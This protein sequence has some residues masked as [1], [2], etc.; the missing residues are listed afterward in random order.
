[1]ITI[2]CICTDKAENAQ[3]IIAFV[4]SILFCHFSCHRKFKIC[5]FRGTA[6]TGNQ[7]F[8]ISLVWIRDIVQSFLVCY[9]NGEDLNICHSSFTISF[10]SC[11]FFRI[12][13]PGAIWQENGIWW[14]HLI[15][16][17]WNMCRRGYQNKQIY[18]PLRS[19]QNRR[20]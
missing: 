18:D 11:I 5:S 4:H 6:K 1:M 10:N 15:V 9:F 16:E 3:I 8:F 7:Q 17:I 12:Q 2:R 20:P 13:I 19:V 14:E